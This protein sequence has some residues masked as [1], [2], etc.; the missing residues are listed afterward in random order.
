MSMVMIEEEEVALDDIPAMVDV[1]DMSMFL[2]SC[3]A[4]DLRMLQ[5]RGVKRVISL[6][7]SCCSRQGMKERLTKRMK[8]QVVCIY[9]EIKE[10]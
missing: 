2:V 9:E 3:D 7:I 4:M 6:V 8:K 10:G 5:V 1:P